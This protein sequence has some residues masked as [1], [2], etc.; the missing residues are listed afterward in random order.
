MAL[1][2]VSSAP[3]ISDYNLAISKDSRKSSGIG[4]PSD[5][6]WNYVD[7]WNQARM[8]QYNNDYNF[9][10]WQQQA[11]YNSP[12]NQVARLKAAGL[13]PNFNSIDGTGNLGSMPTSSANMSPSIGSNRARMRQANTQAILGSVNATLNAIGEGV[14]SLSKL[15]DLPPLE[16]LGAYRKLL[17]NSAYN[18]Q[19]GQ[20]LDNLN[21]L[22]NALFQG[23]M[24]G[25]D[26]SGVK[27]I[28]YPMGVVTDRT[29]PDYMAYDPEYGPKMQ[30]MKQQLSNLGIDYDIKNL[31][32]DCK[33]YYRDNIQPNEKEVLEGKS[34]MAAAGKV[35]KKIAD[36]NTSDLSFSEMLMAIVVVALSR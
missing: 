13:N 30:L 10:L 1:P 26:T 16:S 22:I 29:T 27:G 23:E 14:S 4:Q 18:K 34:G 35:I 8:S 24:A 11:E 31:V 20:E 33:Q 15:S 28:M 2:E 36:G 19:Y 5:G 21:K 12:S 17:L 3:Q 9:W 6:Q 7:A 32:K 25:L